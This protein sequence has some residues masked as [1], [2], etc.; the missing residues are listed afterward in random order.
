MDD[1][2]LSTP[3]VIEALHAWKEAEW[4]CS[5][6]EWSSSQDG[7]RY[8]GMMVRQLSQEGYVMDLFRSHELEQ[9]VG[10]KLSCPREWLQEDDDESDALENY[11]QEELKQAQGMVGEQLW[12]AMRAR[13]D[14]LTWQPVKVMKIGRR[15]LAYLQGTSS[16][17]LKI[18]AKHR[19]SSIAINKQP[20]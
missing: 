3:E 5:A 13:P 18:D 17:D 14:L 12:L 2:Y 4:P 1:L 6:L 11:S 7:T 8:L 15:L 9:A 19:S 10:T 20:S 16:M